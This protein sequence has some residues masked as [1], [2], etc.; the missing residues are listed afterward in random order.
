M[1]AVYALAGAGVLL[2]G[3]GAGA[4]LA[5]GKA[6]RAE[7][8]PYHEAPGLAEAAG[9]AGKTDQAGD[10]LEVEGA[11]VHLAYVHPLGGDAEVSADAVLKLADGLRVLA[12]EG[13]LVQLGADG[14]LEPAHAVALH[15]AHPSP[16][17]VHNLLTE[18]GDALAHGAGLCCHVVGAGAEHEVAPSGGVLAHAVQHGHGL[19]ADNLHAAPYLQLLHV[20]REVTAGHALVDVLVAGEV[21][22]LLDAGL[23]IMAGDA[24]AV[25]NGLNI[26]A[27]LHALVSVDGLLRNVQPQVLLRLHHGDPELALQHDSA[28]CGPNALHGVR[29]IAPGQYVRYCV[30][31][32]VRLS[33]VVVKRYSSL[34]RPRAFCKPLFLYG[35]STSD[36]SGSVPLHGCAMD[37]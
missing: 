8:V 22:E 7:L 37:G 31:I 32:V 24:L 4:R 17:P 12:E 2:V 18:H 28:L 30:H 1:E 5:L 19:V 25:V 29:R 34:P 20:L 6:L 27:A 10:N 11:G 23:H 26:N 15:H 21:A 16:G 3:H 36:L 9:A 33:V 35:A 14:A 13:E